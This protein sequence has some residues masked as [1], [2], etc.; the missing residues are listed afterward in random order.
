I[1]ETLSR[2][3][4]TGLTTLFVVIILILLGGEVIRTLSLTL[5][6]GITVGTYSSV[7]IASPLLILWDK[8]IHK[9]RTLRRA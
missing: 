8:T 7:F 6:I 2:T 5:F 1:N 3:I 4:L 9:K